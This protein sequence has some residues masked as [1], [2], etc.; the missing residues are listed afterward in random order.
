MK[1]SLVDEITSLL[2]SVDD[3]TLKEVKVIL[4]VTTQK[5]SCIISRRKRDQIKEAIRQNDRLAEV[6]PDIKYFRTKPYSLREVLLWTREDHEKYNL[7]LYRDIREDFLARLSELG[8]RLYMTPQELENYL[9]DFP[10]LN[11][12]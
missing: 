12:E 8:L 7:K 1:R 3:S 6:F 9:S 11:R 5:Q 2:R 4:L 10:Y